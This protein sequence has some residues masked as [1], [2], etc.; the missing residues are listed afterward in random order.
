M[1]AQTDPSELSRL[2][3]V[4]LSRLW[5]TI[6]GTD[7]EVAVEGS[8]AAWLRLR[9][10]E[11]GDVLRHQLSV[12]VDDAQHAE[13][14][15]ALPSGHTPVT[16][17]ARLDPPWTFGALLTDPKPPLRL[18]ER[19]KALAKPAMVRKDGDLPREVAGIVYYGAIFAAMNRCGETITSLSRN[20]LADAARW[21]LRRPWLTEPLAALFQEALQQLTAAPAPPAAQ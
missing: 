8:M 14:L 19:V 6:D 12:C 15:Q 16:I 9:P 1:P 3:P 10:E 4:H 17:Q 18:L 5:P 11:M 13:A 2:D 20:D 7:G 21:A